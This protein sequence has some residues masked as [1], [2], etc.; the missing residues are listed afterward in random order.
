M[1]KYC[2]ARN[3]SNATQ[4]RED[5]HTYKVEQKDKVD[6]TVHSD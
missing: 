2:A 6:K 3:K 1:V 4:N 5:S